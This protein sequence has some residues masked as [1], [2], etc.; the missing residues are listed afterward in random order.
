MY[1]KNN[2]ALNAQA[3]QYT[4]TSEKSKV[5]AVIIGGHF[6]GLGVVRS[7]GRNQ[8]PVCLIDS[9][10]C[11]G[12]F[13][14]YTGKFF[15]CPSIRQESLF[16]GFLLKLCSKEHLEGWIIY[17]NDDETVAFLARNKQQL[18]KYYHVP[19]PAWE[20]TRYASEKR[21]TYQLAQK[22]D[23]AVPKTWYPGNIRELDSLD[24]EFPVILKPSVKEPFYSLTKKKA[25]QVKNR[26]DLVQEY[27]QAKLVCPQVELMIQELIPGAPDNL[28]SL[29]SFFHN[30]ELAGKVVAK[31]MR[32]HP[33]DFGHATTY[34]I[35][36]DVPEL[37]IIATRFLRAMGYY[38]LSEIEFMRDSRDGK[39]KL[40]EMNARP[41]GWH[42]LAIEA[43]ADLPYLLYLDILGYPAFTNG[44]TKN[45]KWFHTVTDIPTVL[46][47]ISKGH[48]RIS[49]YFY[50]LKGR[51]K[52]A[53]FSASDPLPFIMEVLMLPYLWIRRGF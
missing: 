4:A 15:H 36:V 21:L 16:L 5:G 53:V 35:T 46:S 42:T 52:D 13:S 41:W 47:E 23:I 32:Q 27:N 10:F 18:E 11:I 9:D 22:I 12:R 2:L 14:K 17:P 19:T 31:R 34:A 40:I 38:G 51:K 37:E 43:G 30:N 3:K 20:I 25:I 49:D 29:G 6:Q 26:R 50:S 28:F 1:K 39:Y 33:M 8:V 45:I 24:I 48:M 44:F 7:L